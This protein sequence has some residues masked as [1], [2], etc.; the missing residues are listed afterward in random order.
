MGD[1]K[2]NWTRYEANLPFTRYTVFKYQIIYRTHPDSNDS[3]G[4]FSFVSRGLRFKE[5]RTRLEWV[6]WVSYRAISKHLLQPLT[7]VYYDSCNQLHFL[8]AKFFRGPHLPDTQESTSHVQ[9]KRTE[10]SQYLFPL[11]PFTLIAL[12]PLQLLFISRLK[13]SAEQTLNFCDPSSCLLLPSTESFHRITEWFR[14]EE[15]LMIIKLQPPA[16]DRV[17]TH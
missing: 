1:K 2:N 17:G 15:T 14:L 4:I 5:V 8:P 11:M 13:K 7:E 3:N 12:F 6:F 16:M 10:N 9:P